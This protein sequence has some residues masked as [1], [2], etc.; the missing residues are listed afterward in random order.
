MQTI[1]TEHSANLVSFTEMQKL[2]GILE[3]GLYRGFDSITYLAAN[4]TFTHSITGAKKSNISGTSLGNPQAVIITPQGSIVNEDASVVLEVDVN[5]SSSE[6]RTDFVV[7]Q[8]AYQNSIGGVDAAF[9]IIKGPLNS[10][11]EPTI[12]SPETQVLIG[13]LKLMAGAA[14]H[15]N[16]VWERSTPPGLGNEREIITS[17]NGTLSVNSDGTIKD[18][19]INTPKILG[20]IDLDTIG[21]NGIYKLDSDTEVLNGPPNRLIWA[22]MIVSTNETG[23]SGVVTTQIVISRGRIYGRTGIVGTVNS[24]TTWEL[25][26]GVD[27]DQLDTKIDVLQSK[28]IPVSDQSV[29]RLSE[30]IYRTSITGADKPASIPEVTTWNKIILGEGIRKLIVLPNTLV[31]DPIELITRIEP[32]PG[33]FSIGVYVGYRIYIEIPSGTGN[34]GGVGIMGKNSISISPGTTCQNFVDL[35]GAPNILIPYG[36]GLTYPG[37]GLIPGDY[38]EGGGTYLKIGTESSLFRGAFAVLECVSISPLTWY[39]ASFS[40]HTVVG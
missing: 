36:T 30:N 16:T 9:I 15:S 40:N 4:I 17:E 6:V 35:Y 34:G 32:D 7:M 39:L 18:L 5:T 37:P 25:S 29:G 31:T 24:W 14:D 38:F 23:G 26:S 3:P 20:G 10:T 21:D 28:I 1:Y 19:A 33:A 22:I 12:T 11:A 13:K 2:L 27:F 8:H